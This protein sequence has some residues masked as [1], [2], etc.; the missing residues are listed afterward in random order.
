MRRIRTKLWL[1]M[2]ILVGIIIFLLWMF[3]IVFLEEF[4]SV[5]ELRAITKTANGITEEIGK[6]GDVSQVNKSTRIMEALDDFIYEKQ[7][8][9]EIIDTSYHMVYQGTY[10]N[11]ASLPG[12]TKQVISDAAQNA[13]KGDEFQQEVTH[14]KF[15]YQFMIISVPIYNENLVQGAVVITFP[16]ASVEDTTDILKKQL[17]IITGILL[18]VSAV[19]SFQLSKNFTNPILKISRQAENYANGQ[20]TTRIDYI[21]EDEI[22][23][24]VKRMNHMGEALTRNDLLQKELIANVSHELRTPLT[25]IRGYAETLRDITGNNLEKRKKQLDIIIVESER[26]SEIVEDILSL[27]QLQ[28]GAITL[29]KTSFSLKKMLLNIKERYELQQEKRTFQMI[30]ALESESYVWGDYKRIEQVLYNLI[31][32]AFRHT[33]EDEL[34]EILAIQKEDKV[35][36]EI[37]DHGEGIAKDDLEHIFERYYKGIRID[38]KM[39][40]GTGLGLSIVKSILEMHQAPYGVESEQGQGTVFWFELDQDNSHTSF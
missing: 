8:S 37:R 9:L 1:G 13:L 33:K 27:S 17:I 31:N 35:K 20:F 32:N 4:Y 36:I 38:G 34:V 23:Q 39:N 40:S 19:I 6:L 11:G 30:G 10:G 24:L 3:Q 7:L 28:A 21:G 16:M 22:G 18:F 14:P 12:I 29:E 25:L 15:G 5:L 2:M 26:L